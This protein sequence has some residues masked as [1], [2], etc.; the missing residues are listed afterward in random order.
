MSCRYGHDIRC[1]PPSE[2]QRIVHS[3]PPVALCYAAETAPLAITGA[4]AD[5]AHHANQTP[6]ENQA[7]ELEAPMVNP[8]NSTAEDQG[9]SLRETVPE[10]VEPPLP[11]G[12]RFFQT[13]EF[14]RLT[15]R[16]HQ[17]R[18]DFLLAKELE[19]SQSTAQVP[20]CVLM[21]E[22]VLTISLQ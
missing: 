22:P 4:A 17:E 15:E 6:W 11:A 1:L 14:T 2:L 20:A 7:A 9:H 18:R 16:H 19:R 8:A 10:E 13:A 3:E 21:R 5:L 12:T